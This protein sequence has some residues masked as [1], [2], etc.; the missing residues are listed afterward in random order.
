MSSNFIPPR[1][2]PAQRAWQLTETNLFL[3]FG[4]NTFTG[5]EWGDG[6]ENPAIFNPVKLDCS[7]WARA[8]KAGGFRIAIL[9]AKHHDGFCLWPSG[10]T[11]HSVKSSPWKNGRG[12][13]VREFVDAFRAEGIKVGLYLSPWD[14]HEPCYGTDTYNDFYCRQLT[15]LLTQ[16]GELHEVWFDGACA[17]GPGGRKQQYDW[18]RFFRIVKELQPGAVTFGDGG[19][20]VRWV[21]NERGTAGAT[22]WS[23]VDPEMIR[24]PGDSGISQANDATASADR[25]KFMNEGLSPDGSGPRVW[26]PGE[27]DVSIRPGWFYHEKEDAEVRSLENLVDLYF[28][29][30]GHNGTL[31]L[32]IPPTPEGL[33]ASADVER[34]AEFRRELNRRFAEDLA[35]K[36]RL[37][38]SS[39]MPENPVGYLQDGHTNTYW[40]PRDGANEIVIEVRLPEAREIGVICLQEAVHLGQRIEA[41]HVDAM[42]ETGEWKNIATG[43]TV[44]NKKL[45]RLSPLRTD[46]IRVTIDRSLDTPALSGISIYPA[47]S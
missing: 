35:K 13:V 24:F 5:R 17:E 31:L 29:S 4:V 9:T 6:S 22:C 23:T 25:E 27:C 41:Y 43:T 14:R 19:T 18:P 37:T 46:R 20:D 34:V 40:T 8:A 2:S 45:D 32:N 12:D 36:S 3:H 10:Q 30:V 11:D 21:G 7:Q 39:E 1:P 33:L 47:V 15:E 16:Y 38:A 44:G 26:S 28:L 42:I